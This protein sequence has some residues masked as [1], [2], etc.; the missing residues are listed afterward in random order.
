[1]G[2]VNTLWVDVGGEVIN[3]A[4]ERERERSEFIRHPE[5]KD[6]ARAAF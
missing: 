6:I 2:M 3:E 5:G 4:G 1:M